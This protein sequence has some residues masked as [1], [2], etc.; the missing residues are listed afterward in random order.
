MAFCMCGDRKSGRWYGEE[1]LVVIENICA[2]I[3]EK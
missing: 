2:K 1:S 3:D